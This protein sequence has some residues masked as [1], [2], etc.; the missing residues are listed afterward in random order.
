MVDW[1]GAPTKIY[2]SYSGAGTITINTYDADDGLSGFAQG[3]C[4]GS[5]TV[6]YNVF[7]NIHYEPMSEN[8]RHAIAGH[9]TGH[10]Q[11]LGHVSG[12]VITLMGYNPDPN[13]YYTP[14]QPD[15][16]LVNMVYP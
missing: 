3:Y 15:I 5:A 11:A 13:S 7:G 9:E 1:N 16:D 8:Q 4:N 2:F 14:Q 10:S 12:N 6:G